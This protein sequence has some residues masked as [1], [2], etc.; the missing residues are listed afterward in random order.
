MN[1]CTIGTPP[2]SD[3]VGSAFSTAQVDL[4]S[5]LKWEKRNLLVQLQL[6]S[7]STASVNLWSVKITHT[8]ISELSLQD[9]LIKP[10]ILLRYWTTISN[11]AWF[12]LEVYARCSTW[13]LSVRF[14]VGANILRTALKH[15][16]AHTSICS[17]FIDLPLRVQFVSWWAYALAIRVNIRCGGLT[18][19]RS[20][21]RLLQEIK[22]P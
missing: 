17:V 7:Y 13:F 16:N 3:P 15:Q 11:D 5:N 14:A 4:L 1:V 9:R 21:F 22:L 20:V 12:S 10:Y 8:N 18:G 6:F 19:K 2:L